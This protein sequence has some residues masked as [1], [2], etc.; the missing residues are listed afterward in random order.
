M[1]D[2]VYAICSIGNSNRKSNTLV[3][4]YEEYG[5]SIIKYMN[6]FKE[7][8][9]ILSSGGVHIVIQTR[10]VMVSSTMI[11]LNTK[12]TSTKVIITK[13]NHFSSHK[14]TMLVSW[15]IICG[16]YGWSLA[17]TRRRFKSCRC[18]AFSKSRHMLQRGQWRFILE[19][20]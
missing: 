14:K 10:H 19:I 3:N 13:C 11:R 20:K 8:R 18:T 12:V 7:H 15:D 17:E 5:A 1:V 6:V 9:P 16:C 4:I 2:G